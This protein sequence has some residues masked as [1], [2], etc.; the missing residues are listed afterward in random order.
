MLLRRDY[1]R[2]AEALRFLRAHLYVLYE[3]YSRSIEI[4][5]WTILG[6][7]QEWCQ[8]LTLAKTR[9]WLTL[10][11]FFLHHDTFPK[12]IYWGFTNLA[13]LGSRGVISSGSH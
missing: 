7:D 10:K 13:N 3:C 4:H 8:I 6:S 2:V 12:V 11:S 1:Q 5:L 9:Q